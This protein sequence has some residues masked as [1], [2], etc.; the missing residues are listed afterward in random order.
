MS[1]YIIG[2]DGGATKTLG[3]LFDFDGNEVKRVV[4]DFSNFSVDVSKTE[5]HIIQTIESLIK[6]Y[7]DDVSMIQMGIAGY[8][9]YENKDS[10]I[11]YLKS[12]Y[13]VEVCIVTDAEVALYSVRKDQNKG[14][15]MVLGGTGSVVMVGD[16]DNIR[17]IGGFGHILGDQGSGYHLAVS[18]LKNVIN[19][20]E[21]GK[22][23]T[24]LSR[25]IL[26]KINAKDYSEIK[27]FVYNN[28]KSDIAKLSLYIA[29]FANAGNGEAI[30]LFIDEGVFLADQTLK[31]FQ[32]LKTSDE[33][34]IGIKGGFLLKAP[35]VKETL[36]NE[37]N[38]F[39]IKYIL[40]DHPMEPIYGTYY[41]AMKHLEKR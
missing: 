2:I 15:I 4:E 35:Y 13:G 39:G 41:L 7:E 38:K 23:I 24:D 8:T 18:A 28:H 26:N 40:D 5:K 21:S 25:E 16:E 22:R 9:N 30:K 3:V 31:A 20:F 32:T 37:I 36:I 17:F 14:T 27:N 33:I 10:F 6:G 34:I 19:Q 12:K 1:K 29:E 11:E